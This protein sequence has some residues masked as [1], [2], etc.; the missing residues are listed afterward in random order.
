VSTPAAR[1]ARGRR[2]AER[3]ASRWQQRRARLRVA[4]TVAWWG[5]VAL[6]GGVALALA[7]VGLEPE[8]LDDAGAV[9]VVT[10]ASWALAA[11]TGGRTLVSAGLAL[12]LGLAA[13]LVGGDV[14]RTGAAVLTC[15]VV[16][17]LAVMVTVPAAGYVAAVREVLI[18]TAVGVLGAFAAIGF[19]PTLVVTRFEY[20]TLVLGL[21]LAFALVHRLGAGLHG[22]GR[23]GLLLVLVAA[24][25]VV[26][27]MV[28][29][30]L[31]RTYGVQG[32][33]EPMLGLADWSRET[34][35]A[36]PRPMVVL[37][38]VPALAWGCHMRARRRQ[39]W[40]VCAFGVTST[41]SVAHS[42]VD[43][44][45][46]LLA[47]G[48]QVVYAVVLGL[49]VGYLLVRADLRLTGSRGRGGRRAE[50]AAAHRP[51]PSRFQAL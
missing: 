18:A 30:E 15:V 23:R 26:A 14:L 5:V 10:T 38:G 16:G 9:A 6:A 29:A 8:W 11:R 20:A 35:G 19:E 21:L 34:I 51:E 17:V 50:Q 27:S 49:L 46:S 28:Y 24:L 41:V 47:A 4:A 13:V 37:L 7:T 1:A 45:A 22:I 32:V 3:P 2:I 43:P 42:L 48:L 40:W 25:L 44:E 31:L 39:G 12:A 33:V 36:F